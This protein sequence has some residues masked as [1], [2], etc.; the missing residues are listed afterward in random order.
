MTQFATPRPAPQYQQPFVNPAPVGYKAPQPVEVYIL[1]DHANASIPPEIRQQFQRDEQGRILWFTTPPLNAS[2]I[3][4]RP[5]QPLGHSARYLAAKAE[6]DAKIA[7]KRKAEEADA[8]ARADQTK[9]AR[10]E[11]TTKFELDVKA[12]SFKAMTALED[13]LALATKKDLQTL[14]DSEDSTEAI[15]KQLDYLSEVQKVAIAK[16]REREARQQ[17]QMRGNHTPITGMTVRLEEKY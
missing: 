8:A 9:K 10:I 1:N 17:Q 6:R 3:V 14:F 11:A 5:G 16:N 12:L 2:P 4:H 7:A 13:Q 15:T